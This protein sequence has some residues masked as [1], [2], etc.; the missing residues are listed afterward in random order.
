MKAPDVASLVP[1]K[2]DMLLLT[3]VVDYA[4]EGAS[5]TAEVVIGPDSTFFDSVINGVSNLFAIE[6]MAQ[7]VAAYVGMLTHAP[8]APANDRIGFLLGSRMLKLHGEVFANGE[9]YR[10]AVKETFLDQE[11]AAFDCT[12]RDAAGNLFAEGG[13]TVFRPKSIKDFQ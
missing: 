9:T 3:R 6:Y 8:G 4:P 1:H 11:M 10:V 13:L 12:V 5:L 2:A 7:G